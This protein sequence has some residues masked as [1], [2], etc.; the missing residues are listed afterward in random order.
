MYVSKIKPCFYIM[1]YVMTKKKE[2]IRRR[3]NVFTK[4]FENLAMTEASYEIALVLAKKLMLSQTG[5]KLLSLV[6]RYLQ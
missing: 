2:E 3:Q 5:K 4:R 1:F 6:S